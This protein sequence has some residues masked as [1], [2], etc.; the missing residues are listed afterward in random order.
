MER[1]KIKII[2]FVIKLFYANEFNN[3]IKTRF[4]PESYKYGYESHT[5][6]EESIKCGCYFEE[7]KFRLFSK[8]YLFKIF[9]YD[10]CS[11]NNYIKTQKTI[12][13]NGKYFWNEKELL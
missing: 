12:I 1:Q 4:V 7:T 2:L 11:R 9:F 6:I 5:I 3:L 10:F 13:L 8:M